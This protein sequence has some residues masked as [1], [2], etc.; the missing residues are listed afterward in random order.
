[1]KTIELL[2][3]F[4]EPQRLRILNLL[5]TSELSVS[6]LVE[7]LSLSQSN[8]SHHLKIL[9]DQ[10]LIE[11]IKEGSQKYYRNIKN[12]DL[13]ENILKIWGE[14]KSFVKDPQETGDD[15][16]KL[17]NV[18]TKRNDTDLD[19]TFNA[20]R[21]Q[22]P[23]IVFTAEVAL[24][25]I[26]SSGIAVD[27]GCGTGDFF[28]IIENTFDQIIGI[29]I[30]QTQLAIA[31]EKKNT[32]DKLYLLQSNGASIPL[33]DDSINTVYFRMALRFIKDQQAALNEALRILK[34]K[35]KISIIE[36]LDSS[37]NFSHDFFISFINKSKNVKIQSYKTISGLFLCV[38]KKN[39]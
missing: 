11:I 36:Q 9:K 4:S 31:S 1:M 23:D 15:E 30:S 21:K 37:G 39:N 33:A 2:K 6:E 38:L 7:I 13:S 35:G 24:G 18:L 28:K 16:R 5:Q 14:L 22:Q 27:I 8:V 26:S 25:G 3:T 10:G 32:N 12:P 29:D 34:K 20:W 19:K 17:I